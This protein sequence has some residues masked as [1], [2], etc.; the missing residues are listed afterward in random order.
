MNAASQVPSG[1]LIST[2]VSTN[3]MPM[4]A[5]AVDDD[6]TDAAM[7]ALIKRAVKSRR[8]RS[9]GYGLFVG[10]FFSSSVMAL[11]KEFI[12]FRWQ[13]APSDHESPRGCSFLGVSRERVPVL[14]FVILSAAGTSRSEA[15]AESKDPY[16]RLALQGRV[17]E[18]CPCPVWR[19]HPRPRKPSASSASHGDCK[20]WRT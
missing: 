11:C 18:F 14:Q 6:D 13:T 2:S 5:A 19:W 20:R 8:V 10:W 16:T 4:S 12:A 17:R 1:V 3:S 9:P 7:P 15:P